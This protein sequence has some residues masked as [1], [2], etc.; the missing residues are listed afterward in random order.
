M[1]AGYDA[2][3]SRGLITRSVSVAQ[4]VRDEL[5]TSHPG[6]L[7][8]ASVGPYGAFLADGSEYTGRYG[9]PAVATA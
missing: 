1:A 4:D 5:A 6:V 3:Q 7:V 2:A 8:A 9:V